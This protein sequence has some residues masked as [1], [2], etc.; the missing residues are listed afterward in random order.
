MS[1]VELLENPDAFVHSTDLELAE[2]AAAD[3]GLKKETWLALLPQVYSAWA[4]P[5]LDLYLLEN[6]GPPECLLNMYA[7][8]SFDY[9]GSAPYARGAARVVELMQQR[10]EAPSSVAEFLSLAREVMARGG[11]SYRVAPLFRLSEVYF[12]CYPCEDEA[13][14]NAAVSEAYT[15]L[16]DLIDWYLN[17][18][19]DSERTFR[20]ES[21]VEAAHIALKTWTAPGALLHSHA[22][23]AAFEALCAALPPRQAQLTGKWVDWVPNM[24]VHL[25]QCTPDRDPLQVLRT[26]CPTPGHLWTM[27]H[28]TPWRHLVEEE[29]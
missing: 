22:W 5:L 4:N 13:F 15:A 19:R 2:R 26:F 29:R 24:L 8:V 10:W 23:V 6:G 18:K 27:D 9:S 12:L 20:L 17:P 14:K 16:S 25:E 11:S 28:R 3:P 21:R 1:E 7:A